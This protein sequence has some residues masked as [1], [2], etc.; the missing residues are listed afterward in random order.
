[1]GLIEVTASD[2]PPIGFLLDGIQEKWC[3]YKSVKI[4]V[5]LDKD[6]VR[7]ANI[8]SSI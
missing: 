6:E 4:H 3:L 5:A 1:M 8:K 2:V 7:T